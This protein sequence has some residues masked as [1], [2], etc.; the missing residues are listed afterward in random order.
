MPDHL[1]VMWTLP[2]GDAVWW[3]AFYAPQTTLDM[4]MIANMEQMLG[5]AETLLVRKTHLHFG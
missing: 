4:A 3:G 1:Y 5:N 2:E